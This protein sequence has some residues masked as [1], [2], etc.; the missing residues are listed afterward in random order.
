MSYRDGKQRA[1]CK[2]QNPSVLQYKHAILLLISNRA[3]AA[4][5][6]L[7]ETDREVLLLIANA[8]QDH[9]RTIRS[10]I[11]DMLPAKMPDTSITVETFTATIVKYVNDLANGVVIQPIVNE[12]GLIQVDNVDAQGRRLAKI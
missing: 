6:S 8:K 11:I 4:N 12:L 7:S 1:C 10:R 9:A 3:G 5:V 2:L